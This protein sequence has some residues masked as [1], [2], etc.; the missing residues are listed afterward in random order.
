[1]CLVFWFETL[2]EGHTFENTGMKE[3]IIFK[4]MLKKYDEG[5][6]IFI[7]SRTRTR[8]FCCKNV[9]EFLSSIVCKK[10]IV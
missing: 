4:L 3:S 6:E 7:R 2:N 8:R 5:N 9:L 10:F 1:M